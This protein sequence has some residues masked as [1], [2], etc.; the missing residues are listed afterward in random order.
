[1]SLELHCPSCDWTILLPDG[2]PI[3]AIKSEC[4]KCSAPTQIRQS[5]FEVLGRKPQFYDIPTN[6]LEAIPV[7]E[8]PEQANFD[9]LPTL[10]SEVIENLVLEESPDPSSDMRTISGFV[11]RITPVILAAQVLAEMMEEGTD[12][13]GE[14]AVAKFA[15]TSVNYRK[16]LSDIEEKHN[17]SRG[18]R[19]SHGF[20]EDDEKSIERFTRAYMGADTSGNI[21]EGSGLTQKLGL[22]TL[23]T[24]VDDSEDVVFLRLTE[25]AK[26]AL[27]IRI[28]SEPEIDSE[29]HRAAGKGQVTLPRWLSRNDVSVILSLIQER[30]NAEQKWMHDLLGWINTSYEGRTTSELIDLEIERELKQLPTNRRWFNRDRNVSLVKEMEDEDATS[31]EIR[32]KLH[33]KIRT[34]LTGTLARMKELSLI[35]QFKRGRQSYYKSTKSGNNW[36]KKWDIAG[37]GDNDPQW[38]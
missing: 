19:L 27:P 35:F 3:S 4:D 28:F 21:R 23:G 20:P 25:A 17:L 9:F 29:K 33:K 32:E 11:N 18:M 6:Q 22:I 24:D 34:T 13:E 38:N 1:M 15:N 30:S 14:S 16:A 5:E 36:V 26:S 37:R 12:V 10:S 2:T 8:E 31:E 7:D